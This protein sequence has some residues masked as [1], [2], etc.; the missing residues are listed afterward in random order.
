MSKLTENRNT[1]ELHI[2]AVKYYFERTAGETIFAG[3][4]VAQDASG[5]AV[6][7]K[8]AANLIVLGR[9]EN[10]AAS[11]EKIV[12]KKGCFLFENGTDGEALTLANI[13]NDCY[14]VDDQTVGKIGGTNKIKAGKVI[15]V[16]DD[17]VAVLI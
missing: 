7:A 17:G 12:A 5:N 11:G 16:T 14:I 6:A 9:A 2:G 10:S 13:G 8:D 4:L 15:D 3:S 1:P